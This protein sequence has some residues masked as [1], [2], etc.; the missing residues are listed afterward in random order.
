MRYD[1][2]NCSEVDNCIVDIIKT[3][4]YTPESADTVNLADN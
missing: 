2:K 4:S 3:S 1:K